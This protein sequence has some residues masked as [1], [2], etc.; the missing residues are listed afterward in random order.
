MIFRI[1]L[2]LRLIVLIKSLFYK[3]DEKH[4]S[5]LNRFFLKRTNKKYCNFTSYGRVGLIFLLYY[6]KKKFPKKNHLIVH[7]I[8][9]QRW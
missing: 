3:L 5:K 7:R 1:N 9:C 2:K 4:T 8:I 6:F